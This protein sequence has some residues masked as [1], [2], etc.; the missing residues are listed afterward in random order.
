MNC[1]EADHLLHPYLDRELDPNQSARL[2]QHLSDCPTCRLLAE[3]FREFQSF[4]RSSAPTFTAPTQLRANV[5]AV[6]ESERRKSSILRRPWI[7]AAAVAAVGLCLLMILLP[8]QSK[9]LSA[10]AIL[11]HTGSLAADHLVDIASSDRRTIGAWFADRIGFTPPVVN[12]AGLG[13]S[14]LGGRTEII[15]NRK[16]AALVYKN[17]ADVV[18]LFCWPSTQ[19]Q[20]S[21]G[22]YF[23]EG[24][25]VSTWSNKSCNYIVVA[26]LDKSR[27]DQ[28]ADAMR[29]RTESASVY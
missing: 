13:Y 5:L 26:K 19:E 10:Q 6:V 3:E 7:Y 11:R 22:N 1:E 12:Q 28:L 27:F 2:E 15:D 24:C 14:L 21:D 29:D 18:T 4:F 25:N 8:D 16:V 20:I 9:Q 23:I 17:D